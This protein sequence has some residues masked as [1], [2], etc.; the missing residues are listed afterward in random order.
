MSGLLRILNSYSILNL[1]FIHLL[2][3]LSSFYDTLVVAFFLPDHAR[4]LKSSYMFSLLWG[5]CFLS[6]FSFEVASALPSWSQR[7]DLFDTSQHRSLVGGSE[8]S[9]ADFVAQTVLWLWVGR[10]RSR[11]G[12]WVVLSA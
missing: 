6:K 4:S 7:I 12:T 10:G 3:N 9:Q 5:P 11:G 2:I 1:A 8:V